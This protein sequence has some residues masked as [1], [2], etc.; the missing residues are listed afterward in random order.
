MGTPGY[1][2]YYGAG[3]TF[4]HYAE[5]EYRYVANGRLHL[6][7]NRYAC[8]DRSVWYTFPLTVEDVD[9]QMLIRQDADGSSV[10]VA[11]CLREDLKKQQWVPPSQAAS[12]HDN[13]GQSFSDAAAVTR[14]SILERSGRRA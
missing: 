1:E 14:F 7:D 6:K 4:N 3:L 13:P 12:A 5:D 11:E 2:K 8:E 10:V 9:K